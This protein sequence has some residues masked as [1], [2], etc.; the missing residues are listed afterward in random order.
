MDECRHYGTTVQRR[1]STNGV[2]VL[3]VMSWDEH[4]PYA[5]VVGAVV[6]GAV[7][8]GAVVVDAVVVGAV[9]GSW[10]SLVVLWGLEVRLPLA[11]RS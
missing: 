7:V 1:L 9:D 5:V 8:V 4:C 10:S 6:V 2:R 11:S 3:P